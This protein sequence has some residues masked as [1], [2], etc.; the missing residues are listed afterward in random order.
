MNNQTSITKPCHM[1]WKELDKI[2]NSKNRHCNECSIDII[3]F[4][5]MS[6][7]EIIEYLSERNKEKVCAKMYSVDKYSKLSK[8]QKKVLT[9]H[10]NIKYNVK[11]GYFKSVVLALAGLMVIATGCITQ[12]GEPALT[13]REELV[14]DTTTVE[15]NDSIYVETCN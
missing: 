15:P 1:R 14:P 5:Q 12:V 2:Q 13:C 6:D 9:W 10:E 3:D 4:T 8:V 7:K 11:N